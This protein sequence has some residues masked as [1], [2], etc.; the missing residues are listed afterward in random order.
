MVY[1]TKTGDEITAN[2]AIGDDKR[3]LELRSKLYAAYQRDE[4]IYLCPKCHTPVYLKSSK[5]K[6]GQFF[7]HFPNQEWSCEWMEKAECSQEEIRARKYMGQKESPAHKE[8]KQQVA[9]CLSADPLFSDVEI[10]KIIM[11]KEGDGKRRK[12]DVRAV[13]HGPN[14]PLPIAFEIQLSS[15]FLSEIVLR[16][17]FYRDEGYLLVWVFRRFVKHDPK[18]TQLDIFYP[19]NLNAF[20][21][22]DKTLA[23]SL[24]TGQLHMECHWAEPYL[25]S[26]FEVRNTLDSRIIPFTEL[27]L[28]QDNQQAFF[29]DYNNHEQGIISDIEKEKMRLKVEARVA[30]EKKQW[31]LEEARA[32][33]K[34]KIVDDFIRYC[35]TNS[36]LRYDREEVVSLQKLCREESIAFPGDISKL[37]R[38]T[39]SIASAQAGA[40]VGFRLPHLIGVANH[41]ADHLQPYL[42]YFVAA[43]KAALK[44]ELFAHR[45]SWIKKKR[46]A[47][48]EAKRAGGAYVIGDKEFSELIF[49]LFPKL[50]G[51]FEEELVYS[52]SYLRANDLGHNVHIESK[53]EIV[54]SEK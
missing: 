15:T 26:D 5:S 35:S 24:E 18:L 54:E 46:A 12:P 22:N 14:G 39:Q 42:L 29:F 31:E 40:P 25:T 30:E 50:E 38:L 16:R 44:Y 1:D 17:E 10:E 49:T 4:P 9:D 34:R 23:K 28:D 19:N 6:T 32:K 20:V 45:G 36:S 2:D 53:S 21:V 48:K 13:Y 43:A 27:T 47:W 41:V 11:S 52:N 8:T 7:A 33:H 37:Y 51:P 3:G